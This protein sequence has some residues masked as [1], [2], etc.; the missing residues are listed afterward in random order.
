MVDA[1]LGLAAEIGSLFRLFEEDSMVFARRK[2]QLRC[3]LDAT[4]EAHDDYAAM[5]ADCAAIR[6]YLDQGAEAAERPA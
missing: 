5:R 1:E 2:K 3:I 6:A 4:T